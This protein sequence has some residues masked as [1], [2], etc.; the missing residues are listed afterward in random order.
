MGREG[1][2]WRAQTK[3][4]RVNETRE[5]DMRLSLFC[6]CRFLLRRVPLSSMFTIDTSSY[7]QI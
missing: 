5:L 1:G 4:V 7:L 3:W 2:A 6:F